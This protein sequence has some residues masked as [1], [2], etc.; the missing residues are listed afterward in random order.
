MGTPGQVQTNNE[1]RAVIWKI[2][3]PVSKHIVIVSEMELG[4]RSVGKELL[5]AH[6]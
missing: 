4:S 5:M 6:I 1:H 3:I 2:L